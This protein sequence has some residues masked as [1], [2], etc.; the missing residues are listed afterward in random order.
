MIAWN[1]ATGVRGPCIQLT[2]IQPTEQDVAARCK[3][4]LPKSQAEP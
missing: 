4:R 2:D 1:R 3:R